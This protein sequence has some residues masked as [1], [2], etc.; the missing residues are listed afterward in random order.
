MSAQALRL[1]PL[2][3]AEQCRR[4]HE[5]ALNLIE[6]I[7]TRVRDADLRQRLAGQPGVTFRADR[8]C[9]DRRLV[10]EMVAEHRQRMAGQTP[11]VTG[12]GQ[13]PADAALTQRI[14]LTAGT[15]ARWW[16]DPDT[17]QV[18]P[19]ALQDLITA[20][21]LIYGLRD[22]RVTGSTSGTALDLPEPL[23][24]LAQMYVAL[25]YAGRPI[26]SA[27][28]SPQQMHE[29][30]DLYDAAGMT[31]Q[32]PVHLISPMRFEGQELE[33]VMACQDRLG[34]VHVGN[35]P[36]CGASMPVFP[37]G[38]L[39]LS[40]AEVLA[41]YTLMRL[42]LP[43]MK[44]SFSMG[45]HCMDFRRGGMVFGTPEHNLVD[46]ARMA[47]HRYY[48]IP[49]VG[50]RSIRSMAKRPGPQ[51]SAEKASSAVAG[52]LAGSKYF[53][54][55]GL[56]SL[57]E[58]FSPIQLV[59][60]CEIRDWAERFAAGFEFSDETLAIPQIEEVLRTGGNFLE[61]EQTLTQYQRMYWMP[62]LFDYGMMGS[63]VAGQ[64]KDAAEAARAV[65]EQAIAGYD[66]ALP[67][68][69][70]RRVDAVFGKQCARCGL[71]PHELLP[72]LQS[73]ATMGI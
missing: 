5:E 2:L 36:L 67:E 7:G 23:Q 42:L 50:S 10:D 65:M 12:Q 69:A 6:R 61:Q 17:D 25:R 62:R 44:I 1:P 48:G 55:G 9:I 54:G 8:A 40:T 31:C 39:V 28:A 46:L 20:A 43:K 27:V 32:L 37:P 34:G 47:V 51:A 30:L 71:K 19:S 15:H 52:A 58:L 41:G 49:T 16:H 72:D 22:Q 57:D 66:F 59:I 3:S 26:Y 70:R 29:V 18:R 4:I 13:A 11:P 60:D 63:Y 24:P 14:T 33:I 21:K 53:F 68:D 73:S 38:G 45:L 56:L 64:T 35:M